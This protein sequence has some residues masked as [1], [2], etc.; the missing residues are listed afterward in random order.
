MDL[1]MDLPIGVQM[2]EWKGVKI[3]VVVAAARNVISLLNRQQGNG[4]FAVNLDF[5]TIVIP[6]PLLWR[7]RTTKVRPGSF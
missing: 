3:I 5:R 4:F 1:P 2:L 7:L 6:T